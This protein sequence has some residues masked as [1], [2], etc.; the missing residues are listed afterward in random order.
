[1]NTVTLVQVFQKEDPVVKI[2]KPGC[3]SMNTVTLVQVFEK[4]GPGVKIAKRD[5]T[6]QEYSHPCAGV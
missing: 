2:T 4:E 3:T 5:C 1:M 6:S